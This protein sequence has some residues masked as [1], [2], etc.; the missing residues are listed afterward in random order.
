VLSSKS[1][2]TMQD[3]LLLTKGAL[4]AL[5]TTPPTKTTEVVVQNGGKVVLRTEGSGTSNSA[6]A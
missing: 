4:K 5:F 2:A 1:M 3:R 6:S